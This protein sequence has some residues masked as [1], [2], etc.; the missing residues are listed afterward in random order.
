VSTS[1]D[2][3][4]RLAAL[5]DDYVY[6]VNCAI[7]NGREDLAQELSDRFFEEATE[8]MSRDGDATRT[9]LGSDPA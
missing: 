7:E 1:P 9:R 8:L 4:A 6:R 2:L 3:S 5:H